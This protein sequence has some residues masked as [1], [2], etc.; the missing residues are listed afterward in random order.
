MASVAV[1]VPVLARPQRVQPLL[2]NLRCS[3]NATH[4]VRAV[5]VC[6]AGDEAEIASVRAAGKRPVILCEPGRAEYARKINLAARFSDEEWLLLAADDLRFHP[7]WLDDALAVHADTGAL[8]VGTNDLGNPTVKQGRHSTHPLVH[9]AYLEQGTVDAPGLLLHEG[10]D[11]NCVDVELVETAKARGVWAFATGSHVEHLHP[12][13]RKGDDDLVYARGRLRYSE[14]RR[15][16]M[17]RQRLWERP[18]LAA[19]R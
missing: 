3:I 13:W 9:R 4:Q 19:A 2:D 16:L 17:R 11:H 14:D 12:L 10:Y 15:L 7:G 6:S 8:V 1:I 18:L 5:F